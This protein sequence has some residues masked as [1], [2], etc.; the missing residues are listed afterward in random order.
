[1]MIMDMAALEDRLVVRVVRLRAGPDRNPNS[2]ADRL[3]GHVPDRW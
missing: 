3:R 1:M 2:I